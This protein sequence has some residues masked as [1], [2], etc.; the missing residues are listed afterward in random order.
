M[1]YVS[2]LK[3]AYKIACK[4]EGKKKKMQIFYKKIFS[5]AYKFFQVAFGKFE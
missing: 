1:V 5:D 4:Y 3:H 2:Y